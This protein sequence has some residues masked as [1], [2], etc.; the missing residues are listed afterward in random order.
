ML[1]ER[2][3]HQLEPA[4]R[5]PLEELAIDVVDLGARLDQLGDGPQG[6]RAGCWSGETSRCPSR[7]PSAGRSATSGV[8][9]PPSARMA[10]MTRMPGRL[11][12]RVLEDGRPQVVL[13]DVMVDHDP[14]ARETGG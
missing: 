3:A 7:S 12:R 13:A 11:G 14:R 5:V 6:A 8:N 9:E 4:E 2:L 1:R 10:R